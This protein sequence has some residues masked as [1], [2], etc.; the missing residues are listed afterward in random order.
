MAKKG[1]GELFSGSLSEFGKKFVMILKAF[2]FLYFIPSI[3]LMLIFGLVVLIAYPG[4]T[5]VFAEIA[6][7][8]FTNFDVSSVP[9]VAWLVVLFVLIIV[10]LVVLMILLNIS[11]I[12]IAFLD[13][14][15][16]FREV[17]GVA[18]KFFW[19]YLW[20]VIIMG[21]LLILLFILLIIPGVIFMIYWIFASY[22]LMNEKKG[23]WESLKR[24]KQIVKGR[25]WRTFGFMILIALVAIVV[26]LVAGFIPFIG[27]FVSTLI[28][29]PFI[30][31]FLKNFY[32]DMKGK[33]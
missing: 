32:L 16:S 20:L 7:S 5:N 18:K 10:V 21:L 6:S 26:S 14:E 12:H 30:T 11:Y 28:L 4:S 3:I 24:S 23:A 19:K 25:W 33:K 31:I 15:K 8:G 2:L 9:G 17:L 22:I 1:F 29:S 13:K 27:G